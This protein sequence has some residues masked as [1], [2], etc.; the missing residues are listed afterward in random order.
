M[1]NIKW[2]REE[3]KCFVVTVLVRKEWYQDQQKA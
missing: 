3:N 1:E 2:F